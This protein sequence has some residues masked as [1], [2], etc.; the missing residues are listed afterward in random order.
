MSM[1]ILSKQMSAAGISAGAA[2]T[3]TIRITPTGKHFA[4]YLYARKANSVAMSEA[5]I[6]TSISSIEV[7]LNGTQIHL[8]KP[9]S[10][11]DY[12]KHVTGATLA[13]GCIP[14]MFYNPMLET[15]LQRGVSGIGCKDV[16]DFAI[17][18]NVTAAN[19]IVSLECYSDYNPNIKNEG[20]GTY[21]QMIEATRTIANTGEYDDN[22]MSTY[23]ADAALM[24]MH[25]YPGTNGSLRSVT[26]KTD[27]FEIMSKA[28]PAILQTETEMAGFTKLGNVPDTGLETSITSIHFDLSKTILSAVSMAGVKTL[29]M[30]TDWAVANATN[31][32]ILTVFMRGMLPKSA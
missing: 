20:V 30:T 25:I 19:V 8:C 21:I 10:Y 15:D 13:T 4:A 22:S 18:I 2:G 6:V 29:R 3:G 27:D 5:E 12:Y 14:I 16:N 24:S 9:K 26:L 23:G 11:R 31:V 1:G 32:T 17:N 28:T 7:T